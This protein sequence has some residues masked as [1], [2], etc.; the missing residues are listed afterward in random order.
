[1]IGGIGVVA[2]SKVVGQPLKCEGV[3]ELPTPQESALGLAKLCFVADLRPM[4]FDARDLLRN[5]G[6]RTHYRAE[7]PVPRPGIGTIGSCGGCRGK[8]GLRRLPAG[9]A[10]RAYIVGWS[11]LE[12]FAIPI[13]GM[14]ARMIVGV[15]AQDVEHDARKQLGKRVHRIFEAVADVVAPPVQS[16]AKSVTP[17]SKDSLQSGRSRVALPGRSLR[18]R[19]SHQG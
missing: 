12:R 11:Q 15:A 13:C 5:D 9:P 7:R 2:R 4:G 10:L 16:A 18:R 14:V 17:E 1:M 3:E 8:H 6:A 19:R